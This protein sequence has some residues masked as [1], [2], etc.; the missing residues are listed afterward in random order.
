MAIKLVC[1]D[2]DGTLLDKNRA[3]STRTIETIKKMGHQIPFILISSRMPQAMT[4]LQASLDRLH[5]PII[6]YNGGL[7]LNNHNGTLEPIFSLGVDLNNVKAILDQTINTQIH[8][9]LYHNTEWY[10]PAM[11]YW[12]DREAN[13][14]KV[15]P[16]VSNLRTVLEKWKTAEKTAHKVM[17]M[18]PAEEIE[19]LYQ[20]LLSDLGDIVHAYRSKDTYIEIANKGICKG[21]AMKKLLS[22]VYDFEMSSVAAFGDNYND[23][24]LLKMSGKGV[25]VANAIPEVQAIADHITDSNIDD[26]VAKY[27]STYFFKDNH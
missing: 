12:A 8:V 19:I 2:I 27:L 11:D 4:H 1:S 7:I 9:S 21:T 10:V 15:S 18:G 13:N 26:G 16:T 23:I 14:T 20:W 5:E 17:C 3:L 24:E 25:A 6:A 22:E